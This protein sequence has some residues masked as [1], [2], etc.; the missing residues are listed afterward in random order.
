MNMIQKGQVLGVP[1][2]AVKEVFF[3][4]KEI[5]GVVR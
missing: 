1:N 5:F 2:G 3:S 4:L